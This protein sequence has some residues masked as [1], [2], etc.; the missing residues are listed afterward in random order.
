MDAKYATIDGTPLY[1]SSETYEKT[2][3]YGKIGTG[4]IVIRTQYMRKK[5]SNGERK[6]R[7]VTESPQR[8]KIRSIRD[9]KISYVVTS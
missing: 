9:N 2:P 7:S 1:L 6:L 8:I 5:A 3:T 4:Q